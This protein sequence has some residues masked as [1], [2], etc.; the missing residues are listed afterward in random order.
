[1]VLIAI[2]SSNRHNGHDTAPGVAV[3]SERVRVADSAASLPN[4]PR[5]KSRFARSN[6]YEPQRDGR[7]APPLKPQ[8]ERA[9]DQDATQ[10]GPPAADA[11]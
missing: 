8:P 1:M 4:F 9:P 6:G 2:A 3:L 11:A 7:Y 10:S 5:W